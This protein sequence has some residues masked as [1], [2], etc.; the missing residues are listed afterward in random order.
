MQADMTV[1]YRVSWWYEAAVP[2]ALHNFTATLVAAEATTAASATTGDAAYLQR[3]ASTQ[4]VGNKCLVC[5]SQA[6]LPWQAGMLD[7]CEL[8]CASAAIVS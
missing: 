1:Q 3:C 8:G 6:K 7:A 4:V 5:L 2:P